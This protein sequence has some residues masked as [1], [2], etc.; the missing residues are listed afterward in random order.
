MCKHNDE[1]IDCGDCAYQSG[2][3]DAVDG[4]PFDNP[5]KNWDQVNAY[6]DGYNIGS[7]CS[8]SESKE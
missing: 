6:Y 4:E 2:Y 5:Y 7:R 3:D 8:M 1:D